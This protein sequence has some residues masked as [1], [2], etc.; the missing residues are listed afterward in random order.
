MT[1]PEARRLLQEQG[2]QRDTP[3]PSSPESESPEFESP[4]S[5]ESQTLGRLEQMLQAT[6]QIVQMV[7][8]GQA[9]TQDALREVLREMMARS[10]EADGGDSTSS[11]QMVE[12]LVEY[13][14]ESPS[15]A[16]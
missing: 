14:T 10:N 3:S 9:Q 7:A 12:D 13:S 5:P 15:L 6:E 1:R 2:R 4:L 8:T 16:C 11:F